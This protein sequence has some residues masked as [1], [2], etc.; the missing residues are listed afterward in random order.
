MWSWWSASKIC[1]SFFFFFWKSWKGN[2]TRWRRRMQ[3]GTRIWCKDELT[4]MVSEKIR[5]SRI[6]TSSSVLLIPTTPGPLLSKDPIASTIVSS[7]AS[8]SVALPL[9]PFRS[10]TTEADGGRSLEQARRNVWAMLMKK[11]RRNDGVELNTVLG[12]R[13]WRKKNK[14]RRCACHK[15]DRYLT[16]TG[17]SC[18]D[19][20]AAAA[21][22]TDDIIMQF[23]AKPL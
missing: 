4:L 13:P 8:S 11:G 21:T 7:K 16:S 23:K 1:S 22:G 12:K 5:V 19:A 2:E 6:C 17:S 18:G 15:H 14:K 9:F 20:P 3:R 10:W